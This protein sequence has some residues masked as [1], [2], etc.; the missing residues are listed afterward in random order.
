MCI[1]INNIEDKVFGVSESTTSV[2]FIKCF[3]A[4]LGGI[5]E[6]GC[7]HIKSYTKVLRNLG[8]IKNSDDLT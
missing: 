7:Y 3:A 8:S 6:G 1:L 4:Y 2:K 5:R